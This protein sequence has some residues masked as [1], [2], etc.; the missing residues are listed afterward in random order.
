MEGIFLLPVFVMDFLMS[1]TLLPWCVIGVGF[2]S[3]LYC[4]TEEKYGFG[5]FSFFIAYGLLDWL[6]NW[7]MS[8]YA[9]HN[10]KYIL[11]GLATY[12]IL[13]L[14]WSICKFLSH[15]INLKK[16]YQK[17]KENWITGNSQWSK[18]IAEQ[19]WKEEKREYNL[20]TFKEATENVIWWMI[21]WPYSMLLSF[22]KDAIY[23]FFQWIFHTFS[24][25]YKRIY[26]SII[27]QFD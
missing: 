13:G 18:D 23:N 3:M 6:L 14:I 2:L 15:M 4:T 26:N 1:L 12:C 21:F 11:I 19:K 20:P 8:I 24:G 16:E 27:A 10:P 22:M 17:K 7:K 5:T 9:Y 25:V